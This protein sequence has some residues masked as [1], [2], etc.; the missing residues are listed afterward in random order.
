[1]FIGRSAYDL[2]MAASRLGHFDPLDVDVKIVHY[3]PRASVGDGG[4]SYAV[5]GWAAAVAGKGTDV[6]VAFD[7]LG[8]HPQT[9]G[10]QWR[11][12]A[13]RRRGGL[14]S[15]EQLRGLLIDA[16]FLVLHSG[17]VY[18]NV[19][20]AKIA[21]R[22]SVPYVLTPHGA[23]HP[24]VMRRRKALKRTW[25]KLME[26]ELVAHA[27]AIHVFYEGERAFLRE[28]G[29]AGKVI[30]APNGVTIPNR[31]ADAAAEDDYV[32]WMGRFDI[33]AKGIDL[34]LRALA[35]LPADARPP[36]R[37]HGPDWRGGKRQ[38]MG[39]V[40]TLGL[41]GVV[42][43]GPAV[44]GADKWE[45]LSNARLF[46]FPSRWDAQSIVA[47]EA[48]GIGVPVVATGTTHLGLHLARE[49][50]A[51]LADA[52]AESIGSAILRG[53]SSDTTSMG[54]NGSRLVK[55]EF[56][57]STAADRYLRQLETIR[58]ET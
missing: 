3:Y 41:E 20:A 45:T 50:A 7:A 16:D 33:E 51:L 8:E 31:V 9:P 48:A 13:H 52:N 22:S 28:L 32:L 42:T 24:S 40:R 49:G 10:V 57:W 4:C 43:I 19:Q 36:A 14:S 5:R 21:I 29:F 53:W 38:A 25:W 18:H 47:L 58:D 11:Q 12:V 17:W 15:D 30:V 44:Y 26:R 56:S 39:L 55:D 35:S 54:L 1:M 23:Y 2:S 27:A 6:V 46:V 34:L 37:L